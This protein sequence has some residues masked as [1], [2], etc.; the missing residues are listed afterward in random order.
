MGC[1]AILKRTGERCGRNTRSGSRFCGHHQRH[2]D[3]QSAA[4]RDQELSPFYL[5]AVRYEPLELEVA[6]ALSGVDDEIAVLRILIRK[7]VKEGDTEETRK[8]IETLCRA[9]KVQYALAGRSAEGLASS[10][11]RVLD[12]VG[13]ELSMVL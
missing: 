11:A 8:G 3:R 9:I 6:A 12:E 13:S 10:L 1:E 2:P 7:A 5:A 4:G